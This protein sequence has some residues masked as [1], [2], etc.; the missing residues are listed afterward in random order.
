MP[1]FTVASNQK[2]EGTKGVSL[3][4]KIGL[5]CLKNM[6]ILQWNLTVAIPELD[7]E[8]K[9]FYHNPTFPECSVG[10]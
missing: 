8:N 4:F 9:E 6:L 10:Y 1:K 3:T 5:I 2:T 7:D